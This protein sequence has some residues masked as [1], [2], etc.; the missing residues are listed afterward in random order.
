[1][2]AHKDMGLGRVGRSRPVRSAQTDGSQA[3]RARGERRGG[4]AAAAGGSSRIWAVREPTERPRAIPARQDSQTLPPPAVGTDV[5]PGAA[6]FAQAR[7]Y[8]SR[9][10]RC[11]PRRLAAWLVW[12][13]PFSPSS[14]PSAPSRSLSLSLA[15]VLTLHGKRESPTAG[16]R[17]PFAPCHL[18]T[19]SRVQPVAERMSITS[20]MS[21][22]PISPL[23]RST[24]LLRLPHQVVGEQRA[25]PGASQV[26]RTGAIR[27]A[28]GQPGASAT[29]ESAA[30]RIQS[31]ISASCACTTALGQAQPS[32]A[33]FPDLASGEIR[34]MTR[35]R[36]ILHNAGSNASG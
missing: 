18:A 22:L 1:M 19:G 29:G 33:A 5:G 30:T 9:R 35:S 32:C 26:E 2:G 27:V 15:L 4:A 11:Q 3:T 34:R 25:R 8:A 20:T 17:R 7:S 13:L 24:Q 36:T 31:K 21:I 6:S 16:L 28:G 23:A 12:L 14:A 10:A